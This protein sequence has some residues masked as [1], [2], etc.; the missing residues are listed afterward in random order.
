MIQTFL[1]SIA[2]EPAKR[3]I[4][5]W[6]HRGAVPEIQKLSIKAMGVDDHE[7]PWVEL[8]NGLKFYGFFPTKEQRILFKSIK[9]KISNVEEDYF[10]VVMEII[11]RYIV[12]RSLPGETV[13]NPSKYIPLRDPLNDFTLDTSQRKELADRFHPQEGAVFVDVGA[14]LGY[15][16]MRIAEQV[17]KKGRVIAFEADPEIL[18]ILK[19]NIE[20]NGFDNIE[21][22]PK[23]VGKEIGEYCFFRKEGTVNSLNAYVLKNLGYK[24]LSEIKVAVVPV[25]DALAELDVKQVD[26]VNITVNGGEHDAIIGMRKTL[27]KFKPTITLAGWYYV[28][29]D[30]KVCDIVGPYLKSV[31]YKVLVGKLGRVLAWEA[32]NGK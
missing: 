4:R 18:H 27:H 25:D 6:R 22:V 8:E 16:T 5:V 30:Q 26:H 9:D 14:F 17:G 32:R 1:R 31:G 23:A 3:M 11:S 28:N 10:A 20:C 29:K 21:I 7:F 12:P 15:G 2:P 13:Y 24:D 19:K